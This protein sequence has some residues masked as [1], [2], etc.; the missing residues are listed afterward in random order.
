M[1]QYQ[2]LLEIVVGKGYVCLTLITLETVGKVTSLKELAYV[3]LPYCDTV[4]PLRET[5]VTKSD[6]LSSVP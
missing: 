5:P 6:N 4:H 3:K 1:I 2:N